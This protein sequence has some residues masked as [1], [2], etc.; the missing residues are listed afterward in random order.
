MHSLPRNK[1]LLWASLSLAAVPALLLTLLLAPR[2]TQDSPDTELEGPQGF[3]VPADA[4]P[5]PAALPPPLKDLFQYSG[6]GRT[7]AAE[8]FDLCR[9]IGSKLD[10]VEAEACLATGVRTSGTYSVENRPLLLRDFIPPPGRDSLGRVL[11]IGGI[12]GDEYSAVSIIFKWMGILDAS[13]SIPFHLRVAPLANPDGLLCTA[14][15]RQNSH[16][17]DLNRNFPSP[18]W[19]DFALQEWAERRDRDPRRYP[20]PMAQSEPETRF[21]VEQIATLQ[22][23]VIVS[24]HAPYRI[25]DFD[26]PHAPPERLGPL[27]LRRL[28]TYPGSLGRYAGVHGGLPVITIELPHAGIMPSVEMQTEVLADLLDWLADH[29]VEDEVVR[30][31]FVESAAQRAATAG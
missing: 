10:S 18:Q 1:P 20:G 9:E 23:D 17:V 30:R 14:S 26:G 21:L 6:G 11:L 19:A 16:G 5:L 27:A 3:R 24:V 29:L 22:P 31:H 2:L 25:I 15:Q 13:L 28:G 8:V 7:S 12:H 4:P